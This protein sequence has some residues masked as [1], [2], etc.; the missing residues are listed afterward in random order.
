MHVMSFETLIAASDQ[1]KH[2]FLELTDYMSFPMY[3]KN[4]VCF[5]Y[6]T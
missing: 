5:N 2:I 3:K 4:P 6:F 1:K